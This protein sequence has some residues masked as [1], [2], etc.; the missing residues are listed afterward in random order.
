MHHQLPGGVFRPHPVLPQRRNFVQHAI[1][2]THSRFGPPCSSVLPPQI[3]PFSFP[4]RERPHPLFR[5]AP[6][7]RRFVSAFR[8]LLHH[9]R[10]PAAQ[11]CLVS[12]VRARQTSPAVAPLPASPNPEPR[13]PRL[14]RCAAFPPRWLLPSGY[15][16]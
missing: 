5:D 6:R 10:K 3:S 16:T 12:C 13:R 14:L 2:Q 8:P 11:R 1:A 9:F 7:A 15:G 4:T